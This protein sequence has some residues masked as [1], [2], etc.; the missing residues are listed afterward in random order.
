MLPVAPR[1]FCPQ[2]SIETTPTSL[3]IVDDDNTLSSIGLAIVFKYDQSNASL[4]I[5]CMMYKNGMVCVGGWKLSNKHVSF[6][7]GF[8]GCTGTNW[9]QGC[10]G[11][12]HPMI[13]AESYT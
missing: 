10:D 5:T 13:C 3:L 2:D 6:I 9:R 1:P 11:T 12:Q 4:S 7:A 8:F